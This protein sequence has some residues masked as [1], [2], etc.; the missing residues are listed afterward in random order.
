MLQFCYLNTYMFKKDGLW[1]KLCHH[2]NSNIIWFIWGTDI[3]CPILNVCQTLWPERNFFTLG[4]ENCFCPL[5]SY[6]LMAKLFLFLCFQFTNL[7][8]IRIYLRVFVDSKYA[9]FQSIILNWALIILILLNVT[10][11]HFQY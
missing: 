3:R 7:R 1:I 6:I 2:H 5:Y 8:A 10:G 9:H 11:I 4:F